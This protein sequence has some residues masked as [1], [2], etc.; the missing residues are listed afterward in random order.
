MTTDELVARARQYAADWWKFSSK[1]ITLD[2]FP[3]VRA[4]EAVV[5]YFESDKPDA[6]HV[7]VCFDKETGELIQ[8]GYKPHFDA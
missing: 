1:S 5:L 8:G 7:E 4:R 2:D 3:R 6:G